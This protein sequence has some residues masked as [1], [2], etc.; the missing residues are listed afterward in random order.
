MKHILTILLLT[1]SASAALAQLVNPAIIYQDTDIAIRHTDWY[2][3]DVY[4]RPFAPPPATATRKELSCLGSEDSDG[5]LQWYYPKINGGKLSDWHPCGTSVGDT[6]GNAVPWQ[7]LFTA[8]DK[9]IT[10]NHSDIVVGDTSGTDS[11]ITVDSLEDVDFRATGTIRLEPG[12]HIMPGS[13]FHAYIA[14]KWGD[15]VFSDNFAD[16]AKF[17]SQWHIFDNA[18]GWPVQGADCSYDTNLAIVDDPDALDG[19]ALRID[20]K[21]DSC[22][23]IEP[24]TPPVHTTFHFST[25]IISGSPW[26]WKRDSIPIR[27]AYENAPY[28]KWEIREKVPIVKHH[29]NSY[30]NAQANE[31]NMNEKWGGGLDEIHLGLSHNFPYGPFQGKFGTDTAGH[32][33]FRSPAAHFAP[34]NDPDA[35]VINNFPYEVKQ[36]I[37]THHPDTLLL[38][39]RTT[40]GEGGF[41]SSLVADSNRLV[42]FYYIKKKSNVSDSLS[43]RVDSTG[44]YFTGAYADSVHAD[45]THDTLFFNKGYQPNSI[46]LS[47]LDRYYPCHWDHATG[48]IYLTT[49]LD[50]G[51]SH[52][53]TKRFSY[54]CDEGPDYPVAPILVDTTTY[55]YH[56]Y[57]MEL[58]PHEAEFLVD[59]A[60]RQRYPDH[61][62]PIGDKRYDYI[63]TFPRAPMGII[64]AEI[65]MDGVPSDYSDTN[66]IYYQEVKYFEANIATCQGCD[67]VESPPGSSHF[68]HTAHHLVDYFKIWDLPSDAKLP[69]FPR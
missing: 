61:L 14:P 30:A 32:P 60:V 34:W 1:C 58:L 48:K 64:P 52:I 59:G 67:L 65:D 35:V 4:Y 7:R 38:A 21:E 33:A 36:Q 23:C 28:G 51:A 22:N 47:L 41:P 39:D 13:Y 10:H 69:N 15:S 37:N 42:T 6:I 9:P 3:R 40:I 24:G 62:I 2:H 12:F 25:A 66:S 17:R 8:N 46:Q 16:T 11:V 63:T 68:Q 57:T 5:I 54:T 53:A 27:S 45:G 50:S 43:W 19:R 26:P 20:L 49:P 31:W 55:K 29:T 18:H 44:R 56:T